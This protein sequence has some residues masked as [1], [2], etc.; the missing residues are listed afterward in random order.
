MTNY[1][2]YILDR[3]EH[4][5][6]ACVAECEGEDDIERTALSLLADHQAAT[7]VEVWER[8]KVVYRTERSKVAS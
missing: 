3:L 4:I 2:I 1:R 8:D 7:A 6:E 5:T